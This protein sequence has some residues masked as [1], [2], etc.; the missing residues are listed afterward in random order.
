[1]PYKPSGPWVLVKRGGKWKRLKRHPTP[2][3]ARRHAAA[4]NAKVTNKERKR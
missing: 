1:M 2:E 3:K 4:L